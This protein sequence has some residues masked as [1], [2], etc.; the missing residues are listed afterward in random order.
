M[1]PF[2]TGD[3]LYSDASPNSEYSLVRP[4]QVNLGPTEISGI[5]RDIIIIK[6]SSSHWKMFVFTEF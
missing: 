6:M 1:Q 5:S 4:F 3:Q 2:K